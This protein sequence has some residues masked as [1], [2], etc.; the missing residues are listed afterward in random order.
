MPVGGCRSQTRWDIDN[1]D[2]DAIRASLD[3]EWS[4]EFTVGAEAG[5]NINV[6]LQVVDALGE[7]ITEAKSFFAWLSDA[8]GGAPTSTAPDNDVVIGTDGTI[9]LEHTADI[10][11]ELL[12]ESDGDLDLDIGD[13]VGTPTFYLNVRLAD[14]SIVSSGAITFA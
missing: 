14:G 5:N 13:T 3:I 1:C 11:F 7:D 6:A 4:V 2:G 9:L 8:A 12:T 10:V